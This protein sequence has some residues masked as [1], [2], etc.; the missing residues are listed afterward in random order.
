MPISTSQALS[1]HLRTFMTD[2]QGFSLIRNDFFP[3]LYKNIAGH[4]WQH[5]VTP[6]NTWSQVVTTCNI[7]NHILTLW[8]EGNIISFSLSCHTVT[9]G[10]NWSH[11][12]TAGNSWQ[13]GQLICITGYTQEGF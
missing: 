3:I 6:G 10:H 2:F 13:L 5:L 9:A 12:V 7:L 4:T 11:L 8:Q 1:H